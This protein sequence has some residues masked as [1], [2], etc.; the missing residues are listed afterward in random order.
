MIEEIQDKYMLEGIAIGEAKGKIKEKV[1]GILTL[2]QI[3]FGEVPETISNE[4]TKRT[5]LVALQS[6][7][8]LAAQCKSLDE[9]TN[10]LK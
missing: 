3:H 5:D 6:L 10:A 4:L 1:N 2:L 8:V 9:F 7:F